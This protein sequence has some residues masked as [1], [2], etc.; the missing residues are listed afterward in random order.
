MVLPPLAQWLIAGYGW[1]AAYFAMGGLILVLGIPLTALYVRE[2]PRAHAQR[3]VRLPGTSV[4]DCL[5]QRAF[6]ILVASLFL[7]SVSVNA[8]IAHI[9]PVLTDRGVSPATAALAASALGLSSFAGRL[10]TGALL[11][12]FFGPRVGASLLAATAIGI[13]LLSRAATGAAGIAAAALIGIGV[14]A[15]ADFTPYVLTRYF[16]LRSFSTL[17]GLTWTAYAV[18]GGVGPVLMG[19]AFDATGSYASLLALLAAGMA[20]AALV[21]LLLPR[22][23]AGEPA[24]WNAD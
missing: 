13:L 17:Y 4:R 5:R 12:R 9:S 22:Y 19:R 8:A 23:P 10:L 2:R 3:H 24:V 11:D 15:E 1:R 21:L 14:G 6:W 16:G 18:A 20:M 7:G